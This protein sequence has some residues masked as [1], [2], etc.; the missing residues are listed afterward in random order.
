M[1]I[2]KIGIGSFLRSYLIL[3]SLIFLNQ[4]QNKLGGEAPLDLAKGIL[5]S[6]DMDSYRLQLESTTTIA[7]EQGEDLK[8][9]PTEMRGGTSILGH[10]CQLL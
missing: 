3:F 4:L 9:I 1:H 5:D 6:I 7:L 8:P 2:W 10:V